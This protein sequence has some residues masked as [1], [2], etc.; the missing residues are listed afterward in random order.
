VGVWGLVLVASASPMGSA[1]FKVGLV[2]I[3]IVFVG[4]FS[5]S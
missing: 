1:G 2:V 5:S 3:M 4:D